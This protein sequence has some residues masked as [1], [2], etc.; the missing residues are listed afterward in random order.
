LSANR[1]AQYKNNLTAGIDKDDSAWLLG[2]MAIM[3]GDDRALS[4]L[5]E[6]ICEVRDERVR[7][8]ILD[9]CAFTVARIVEKRQD[10]ALDN[11]VFQIF[12]ASITAKGKLVIKRFAYAV[13][14]VACK[15]WKDETKQRAI[16]FV[17]RNASHPN[18]IVRA[19]YTYTKNELLEWL[20]SHHQ[21]R[22]GEGQQSMGDVFRQ[23]EETLRLS[24]GR[25]TPS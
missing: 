22:Q 23:A 15:G 13:E 14:Q 10:T 17:L 8:A 18:P 11:V 16:V 6:A 21:D 4:S 20:E 1:I 24:N 7:D 19:E 25:P 5:W 3:H 12:D 9:P 2:E